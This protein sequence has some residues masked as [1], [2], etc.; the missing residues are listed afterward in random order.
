[1]TIKEL[2]SR[3]GQRV[4]IRTD[5]YNKLDGEYIL[6]GIMQRCEIENEKMESGIFIKVSELPPQR[7]SYWI[8]INNTKLMFLQNAEDEETEKEKEPI[9]S[10]NISEQQRI[11][12][13]QKNTLQQLKAMQ[14]SDV[15]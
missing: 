15:K 6:T 14:G 9:H 2:K 13:I 12:D 3:M 1:M 5:G 10:N 11:E 8:D 4:Y 7:A